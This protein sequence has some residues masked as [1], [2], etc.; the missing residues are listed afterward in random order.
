MPLAVG[1]VGVGIRGTCRAAALAETG[2]VSL[3]GVMDDV[4]ERATTVAE[5]LG[6]RAFRSTPALFE[7][8]DLVFICAPTR[9][10][11]LIAREATR[12]G[13][14]VFIEWP[15]ATSITEIR[16]LLRMADE[17]GTRI[18]VSCPL[19]FHPSWK[20]WDRYYSPTI[21]HVDW[22][23]PTDRRHEIIWP[24]EIAACVAI[25]TR[26][27]GSTAVRRIDARA[28]RTSRPA[29]SALSFTLQFEN[30]AM[31][32]ALLHGD[33]GHGSRYV[34]MAGRSDVTRINLEITGTVR[35]MSPSSMES[36]EKLIVRE[37]V[38]FLAPQSERD[39]AP[40]SIAESGHISELV[41]RILAKLR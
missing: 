14:H 33:A 1:V 19:L 31:V 22:S 32:Q 28:A 37:Q 11:Y 2:A 23:C 36:L 3:V 9:D 27:V 15:P 6:C 18:G 41:E 4:R 12:L 5:N 39:T 10:H 40:L 21:V 8:T 35:K 24:H 26:R 29:I 30:G 38:A 13:K 16:T 25:V 34:V 17:A 7:E 20:A